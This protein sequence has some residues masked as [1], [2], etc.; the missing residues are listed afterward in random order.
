[1]PAFTNPAGERIDRLEQV[2]EYDC[3]GGR[4]RNGTMEV[5]LGSVVVRSAAGTGRW[6]RVSGKRREVFRSICAYVSSRGN[7]TAGSS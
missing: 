7:G 1:M 2:V 3:T 6:E 4:E 5:K